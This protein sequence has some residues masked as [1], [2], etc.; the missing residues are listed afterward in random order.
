MKL[1][2]TTSIAGLNFSYSAGQ[3][4]DASEVYESEAISWLNAGYCVVIHPRK[5][6]AATTSEN[7]ATKD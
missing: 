4:I 2:F 1:R 7:T 3:V 5:R 6:T